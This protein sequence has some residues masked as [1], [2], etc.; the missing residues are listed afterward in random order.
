MVP[1]KHHRAHVIP[2]FWLLSAGMNC[3][4]K[5]G[6]KRVTAHVFVV[7]C[8]GACGGGCVWWRLSVVFSWCAVTCGE[9]SV[10]MITLM[11]SSISIDCKKDKN[12]KRAGDSAASARGMVVG[13]RFFGGSIKQQSMGRRAVARQG[14]GVRV[15]VTQRPN[16][17]RRPCRARR[18]GACGVPGR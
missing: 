1:R 18:R 8:S 4:Q 7:C 12:C 16:R 17:L 3:A 10:M 13:A 14:V 6:A 9:T 2:C 11:P 15:R 5:V